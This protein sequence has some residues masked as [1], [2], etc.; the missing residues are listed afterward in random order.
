MD[1]KMMEVAKLLGVEFDEEFSTTESS[2]RYKLTKRGL[3]SYNITRAWWEDASHTLTKLLT[4]YIDVEL[5][6]W[7]P[8]IDETYYIPRPDTES[9]FAVTRW[10]GGENDVYRYSQGLVYKT[11][12]E[13][14]ELAEEMLD[15]ARKKFADGSK[16]GGE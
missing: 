4:G 10:Q 5:S 8:K 14:I 12:R 15:V 3:Q 16:T 7:E 2:I 13:A 11:S 1:N 9:R 6:P